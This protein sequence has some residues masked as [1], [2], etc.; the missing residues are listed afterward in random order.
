[1]IDEI[2][3]CQGEI[4]DIPDDIWEEFYALSDDD[5]QQIYTQTQNNA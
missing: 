2:Q 4:F 1:M 3:D 5:L